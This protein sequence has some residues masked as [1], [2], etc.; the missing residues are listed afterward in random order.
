MAVL[1]VPE[2]VFRVPSFC[3]ALIT[4]FSEREPVEFFAFPAASHF[5]GDVNRMVSGR[6]YRQMRRCLVSVSYARLHPRPLDH[7]SIG[8]PSHKFEKNRFHSY[9]D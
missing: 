9:F 5:L 8:I 4:A 3:P 7:R 2:S 1:A 6:E